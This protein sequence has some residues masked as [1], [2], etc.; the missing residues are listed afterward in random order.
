MHYEERLSEVT[1]ITSG[2]LLLKKI[3][4]ADFIVEIDENHMKSFF[5]NYNLTNLIKQHTCYK[6][7]ANP[8]CIDLI[9][10]NV[11]FPKHLCSRKRA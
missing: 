3:I 7:P 9:L 4:F 2:G 5:E 8:K 6:N 11:T 10:T 1:W